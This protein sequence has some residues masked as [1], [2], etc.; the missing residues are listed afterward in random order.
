MLLM[1]NSMRKH[2]YMPGTSSYGLSTVA[3][4]ELLCNH[5]NLDYEHKTGMGAQVASCC[6]SLYQWID[7]QSN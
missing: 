7:K 6:R 1:L 5:L 4:V 3:V 2:Y